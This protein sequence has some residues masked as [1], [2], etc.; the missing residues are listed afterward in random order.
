MTAGLLWGI[1]RLTGYV[2]QNAATN[3][4]TIETSEKPGD[5]HHPQK[6]N[7]LF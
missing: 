3:A 4:I 5:F 2:S 1:V 7:G 6:D